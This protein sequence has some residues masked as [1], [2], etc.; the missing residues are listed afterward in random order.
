MRLTFKYLQK[1]SSLLAC[2]DI[3]YIVFMSKKQELLSYF[4]QLAPEE[5]LR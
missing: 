4:A 2:A 3:D 1:H 5:I